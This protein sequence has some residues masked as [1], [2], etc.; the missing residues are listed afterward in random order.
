LNFNK[1]TV[2]ELL[3]VVPANLNNR[4]NQLFAIHYANDIWL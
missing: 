4:L 3:F 2:E 1:F